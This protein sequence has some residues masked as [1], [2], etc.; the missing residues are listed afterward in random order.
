VVLMAWRKATRRPATRRSPQ[1]P[2]PIGAWDLA[3]GRAWQAWLAHFAGLEPPALSA[4]AAASLVV[5]AALLL[6]SVTAD[7]RALGGEPDG[8]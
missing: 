4:E 8:H 3:Q 6:P 7:L 1:P 2:A 5:A